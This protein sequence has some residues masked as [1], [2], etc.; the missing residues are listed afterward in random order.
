MLLADLD[1]TSACCFDP[2]LCLDPAALI[3][4]P[5]AIVPTAPTASLSSCD[6]VVRQLQFALDETRRAIH[7]MASSMT[8]P[9]SHPLLYRDDMPRAMRDAH[10]GCAM[11]T[12]KTRA[13][14]PFVLRSLES[15]SDDLLASEPAPTL[16]A[17]L[18][19]TQALIL[20]LV[21]RLLDGDIRARAA[22]EKQLD[23]LDASAFALLPHV[24]WDNLVPPA[25][26]A[27]I[28][29]YPAVRAAA[30][31]RAWAIHESAR[32]TF[33][34]ALY[35]LQA[36][37]ILA[38]LRGPDCDHRLMLCR[39]LTVSAAL[40]DASSAVAFARAWN[41]RRYFIITAA[42]LEDVLDEAG[43]DDMDAFAR[44]LL[45]SAMGIEEAEGWFAS[46]GG[47][48]RALAEG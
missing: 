48:L 4:S 8:T 6:L 47:N 17:R 16:R 21:M 10:A 13:N 24:D 15:F 36:Y 7:T 46:K 44:M 5:T 12:T 42:R 20:Y 30:A 3:P 2:D 45:S 23:A 27:F 25:V 33:C 41:E 11:Y 1:D 43:A 26:D 39:A 35:F 32:R 14:A 31:W 9:W 22:A 37:R 19:H 29:L 28:P 40:W 18:A 38:G 34:F